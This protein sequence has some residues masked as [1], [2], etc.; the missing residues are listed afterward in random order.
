M[1]GALCCGKF[2]IVIPIFVQKLMG[3][4]TSSMRGK[5]EEMYFITRMCTNVVI[6]YFTIRTS[7]G[8]GGGGVWR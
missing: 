6:I 4:D 1:L 5:I 8:G 3:S 2:A 7:C